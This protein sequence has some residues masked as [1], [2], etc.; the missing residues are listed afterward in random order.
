MKNYNIYKYIIIFILC[1]CSVAKLCQTLCNSTDC[2]TSGFPVLHYLPKFTQTHAIE[3]VMPSSHLILC[4]P[5]LLLPSPFPS[6]RVFSNKLALHIRWPKYWSF[7]FSISPSNE[8]S[9]IGK[10]DLVGL[11]DLLQ[12]TRLIGVEFELMCV[13]LYGI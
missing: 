8:H 2:G 4:H 9:E 11:T 5:L 10:L 1:C 7:G 12:I 13:K 6:S 3:L